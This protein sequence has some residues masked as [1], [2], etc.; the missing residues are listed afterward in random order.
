MTAASNA[1]ET[2]NATSRRMLTGWSN[3]IPRQGNL[4]TLFSPRWERESPVR[5]ISRRDIKVALPW[6]E[7]REI[8]IPIAS[9]IGGIA[10]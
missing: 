3:S 10:V 4:P 7:G 6:L 5:R 1:Y 2:V 8:P 9:G